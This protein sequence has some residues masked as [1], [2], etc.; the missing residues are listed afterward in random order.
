MQVL[1][2]PCHQEPLVYSDA[3]WNTR[4]GYSDR[5]KE[6]SPRLPQP[7]ESGALEAKGSGEGVRHPEERDGNTWSCRRASIARQAFFPAESP[8]RPFCTG[9]RSI[10]RRLMWWERVC[11]SD[12]DSLAPK[13]L[14]KLPPMGASLPVSPQDWVGS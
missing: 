6:P 11:Q 12:I 7:A 2:D 5:G 14:G 10:W 4:H 8:M 9:K 3:H 13:E 1:L